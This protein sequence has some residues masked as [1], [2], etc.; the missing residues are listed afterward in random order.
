V[1]RDNPALRSRLT[2]WVMRCT[3]EDRDDGLK[4]EQKETASSAEPISP[5]K[6][7][8]GDIPREGVESVLGTLQPEKKAAAGGGEKSDWLV[9]GS[10][11]RM[12]PMEQT[13]LK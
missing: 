8:E 4:E 9:T 5:A 3:K 6:G 7:G 11:V 2:R 12:E 10:Q 13:H 1:N